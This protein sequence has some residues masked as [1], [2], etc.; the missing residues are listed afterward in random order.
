MN[1]KIFMLPA[2][3]PFFFVSCAYKAAMDLETL[4]NASMSQEMTVVS[5]E[6]S[7]LLSQRSKLQRQL[8]QVRS[9]ITSVERK[10][11]KT[12]AGSP[13]YLA[14]KKEL[15]QLSRKKLEIEGDI[16]ALI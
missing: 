2:F 9:L 16:N 5:D 6:N 4:A 10:L 14:L 1:K 8:S 15:Q 3:A 12:A 11:F 13:N 7:V